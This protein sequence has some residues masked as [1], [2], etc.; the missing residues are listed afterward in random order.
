MT[1]INNANDMIK[2]AGG[3][4]NIKYVWTTGSRIYLY[5]V[6]SR[7]MNYLVVL[8]TK[9]VETMKHLTDHIYIIQMDDLAYD[10]TEDITRAL[11]LQ[12]GYLRKAS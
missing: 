9:G 6:D 1:R 11:D 3:C 7:K 12:K 5:L 10:M 8:N 4:K 2:A